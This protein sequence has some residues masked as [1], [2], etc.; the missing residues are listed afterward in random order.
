MHQPHVGSSLSLYIYIYTVFILFPH[1]NSPFVSSTQALQQRSVHY[2]CC[3]P[4]LFPGAFACFGVRNILNIGGRGA[5]P[6]QRSRKLSFLWIIHSSQMFPATIGCQMDQSKLG[7]W[8]NTSLRKAWRS[9][10]CVCLVS[11]ETHIHHLSEHVKSKSSRNARKTRT[12]QEMACLQYKK[13]IYIV[14]IYDSLSV[15]MDLPWPLLPLQGQL[16]IH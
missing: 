10:F 7:T 6:Y 4:A 5:S 12:K 8:G 13:Y 1:L 14:W 3:Y 2:H 15:R 11:W 16:Q 9:C